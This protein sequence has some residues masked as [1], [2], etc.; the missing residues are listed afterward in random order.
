M[1]GSLKQPVCACERRQVSFGREMSM[2]HLLPGDAPAASRGRSSHTAGRWVVDRGYRA[3]SASICLGAPAQ[4]GKELGGNEAQRTRSDPDQR[5]ATGAGCLAPVTSL[6]HL[7]DRGNSYSI[8][9]MTLPRITSQV[10]D[11]Q[12]TTHNTGTILSDEQ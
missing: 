8:S 1:P 3:A 11:T 2:G 6:P 7:Q 9:R 4:P 12:H 10:A 5:V